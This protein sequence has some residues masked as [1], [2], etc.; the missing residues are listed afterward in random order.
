LFVAWTLPQTLAGAALALAARLRGSRGDWYRFGPFLFY[1][2]RA[3]PPA[4]RGISLGAVILCEDPT[5]LVHEMCH[6]FTALWLSWAYLPV[7]GLEYLIVGH[8]RSPHERLTVR[9]ERSCRY[10]FRRMTTKWAP[11]KDAC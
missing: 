3:A 11:S 5:I 4:S 1:V 6:A 9:F 8:A 7:Y 10:G 2:M